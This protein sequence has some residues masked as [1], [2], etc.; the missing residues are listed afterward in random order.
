MSDL[1]GHLTETCIFED[2]YKI[3]WTRLGDS[4]NPP[5]VLVHGTPFSSLE[6]LPIARALQKD[7]SV[8]LFDLPGFGASQEPARPDVKDSDFDV[9]LASH[10]RAFATLYESWDFSGTNLP[11][12]IAHDIGGHA[13]LRA[14]LL[15]NVRYASLCL[16]D[17]VAIK[18]WGSP[19]LRAIQ[20]DPE[21][22]EAIPPAMFKAMLREYVQ[23][24]A[25]KKL[26]DARS[27]EF[28]RPWTD[29]PEEGRKRFIRQIRWMT[30]VHTEEMESEMH[31][32]LATDDGS[33]KKLKIMWAENDNWIPVEIGERLAMLT[34]ASEFVRVPD[35]GHLIQVDQPE[36]VTYELTKWLAK[37]AG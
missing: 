25:H 32:V 31:R 18:P 10:G 19:L 4:S 11:H 5:V 35:A 1:Y 16:L 20:S 14:H 30:P 17:V 26:T 6:W 21:A 2:L 8:Y 36:V 33:P 12:V 13:V 15:H 3:R 7:Y 37:I 22:F 9:G 34:E 28:V 29:E 23:N 24:A 27:D